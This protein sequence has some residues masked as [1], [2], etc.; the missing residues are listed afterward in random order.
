LFS[1]AAGSTPQIPSDLPLLLIHASRLAIKGD[2]TRQ[3][4][5]LYLALA[6]YNGSETSITSAE[7]QFNKNSF[8]LVPHQIDLQLPVA[9]KQQRATL[10]E[11]SFRKEFLFDPSKFSNTIEI[12]LKTNVTLLVFKREI[13]GI[14]LTEVP[15]TKSTE[16]AAAAANNL[17][18]IKPSTEML[19]KVKPP[20]T[21][22]T[23]FTKENGW[24]ETKRDVKGEILVAQYYSSVSQP[25]GAEV[26]VDLAFYY[27][28]PGGT[29]LAAKI[30]VRSI[31]QQYQPILSKSLKTLFSL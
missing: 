14:Y 10:I 6:F 21:L 5:V 25:V 24:I 1:A 17:S 13:N 12:A 2:F 30:D 26:V 8:G 15:N 11:C 28:L 16:E 18:S 31:E 3:Y 4:G 9:S 29:T 23:Y 20:E 7:I 22:L 19:E 27:S